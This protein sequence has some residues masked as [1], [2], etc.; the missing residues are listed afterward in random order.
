MKGVE[1][2]QKRRLVIL[3]VLLLGIAFGWLAQVAIGGR[4]FVSM[5]S[6]SPAIRFDR[7]TGRSW[8][9]EVTVTENVYKWRWQAIHE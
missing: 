4:Y 7:W 1:M 8:R 5:A 9:L 2:D 6:D 3:G